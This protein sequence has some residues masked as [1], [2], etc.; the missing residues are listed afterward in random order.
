MTEQALQKQILNYLD[1]IGAWTVKTITTN[2][3]GTCDILAC[4]PN[5]RFCGIEVKR[6][7][8]LRNVSKIQQYQID[9]INGAG[10]IAFA[11]DS[12]EAV[13]KVIHDEAFNVGDESL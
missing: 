2:K 3:N 8:M 7:G 6:P 1:S 11:A 13:K 5:G 4:L 10:G 9:K 12:L